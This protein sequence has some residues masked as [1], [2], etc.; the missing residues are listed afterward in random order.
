MC[1]H[2]IKLKKYNEYILTMEKPI[3]P[4]QLPDGNF[5]FRG[6]I[7]YAREKGVTVPK[8]TD[9]EREMFIHFYV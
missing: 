1:G 7:A 4:S 3:M 8:L 2:K 6:L 9:W 5:D